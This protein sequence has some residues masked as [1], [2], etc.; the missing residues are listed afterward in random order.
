M[1]TDPHPRGTSHAS[2]D[3]LPPEV[4]QA[5]AAGLDHFRLRELLSLVLTP[6]APAE[7]QAYLA[8]AP[9]DQG[10]GSY[11]RAL[12]MGSIPLQVEVPRTRSAAFRPRLLP[13]PYPRDDPQE[14]QT[15]LLRRLASC[16]SLNAA[17]TARRQMGLAASEDE[18]E[19]VA[20][21]FIEELELHHTRPLDPDRLALFLAA[22]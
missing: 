15:L 18:M 8:N 10:K 9:T 12:K 5:L 7:R 19:T 2:A 1:P 20:R 16:R 3:P 14:T 21:P 4:E 13:P 17:K 11:A 6:L 22:K